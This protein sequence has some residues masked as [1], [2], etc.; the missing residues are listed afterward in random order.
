MPQPAHDYELSVMEDLDPEPATRVRSVRAREVLVGVLLLVGV[1]GWAGWQWWYGETLRNNYE[2]GRQAV[3]EQRWE[4]ARASFEAAAGHKDATARAQDAEKKIEERDKHYALAS[5]HAE[6][7]EWVVALKAARE[8]AAIQPDYKELDALLVEAEE[9]VYREA[10]S[11]SVALRLG[12][13][14]GLYYRDADKWVRLE[15]SDRW[16]DV[17]NYSQH[18]IFLYDVPT[19]GWVPQPTATPVPS[20]AQD[21]SVEPELGMPQ[22]AGRRLVAASFQG[23][24]GPSFYKLNLDPTRYSYFIT[25]RSGVW[26]IRQLQFELAIPGLHP[27]LQLQGLFGKSEI[28]YE[29]HGS[30]ITSTISIAPNMGLVGFGEEGK[31]VLLAEFDPQAPGLG[32]LKLYAAGPDGSQARLVYTT[33]GTIRSARLSPDE[34]YVLLTIVEHIT[35]GSGKM[36]AVLV[37]LESN[38]QTRTLVTADA[39]VS[40]TQSAMFVNGES[41]LSAAFLRR[42]Y[43]ANKIAVTINSVGQGTEIRL[44]DPNHPEW[45]RTLAR[46]PVE[47]NASR[48]T[49]IPIYQQADGKALVINMSSGVE[50]TF[51]TRGPIT[52]SLAIVQVDPPLAQWTY[53]PV[54]AT[55][56]KGVVLTQEGKLD[57]RRDFAIMQV[58]GDRL[59]YGA[60]FIDVSGYTTTF[61]SVPLADLGKKEPSLTEV[62]SVTRSENRPPPYTSWMAGENM[63]VYTDEQHALHVRTYDGALDLVLERGVSF[64]R[65]ERVLLY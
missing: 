43:F 58:A 12:D 27:S 51:V 37:D 26:G 45:S 50:S 53:L 65:N 39:R 1:L 17:R 63:F 23:D 40:R 59:V 21:Q 13:D 8:A 25:T 7:G 61:Y 35:E 14:P 4:E 30:N 11:G 56:Y 3:I 64:L 31:H 36:A 32:A 41:G 57:Y 55:T 52:V 42:G 33:T 9:Q 62:F 34:R 16:S 38:A 54:R 47:G 20:A 29:A 28:A 19:P 22:L 18:G 15:G 49:Y 5:I 10:L 24:A 48:P 44:I 2:L 46:A 60:R 6:A